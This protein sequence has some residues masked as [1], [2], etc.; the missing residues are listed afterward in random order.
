MVKSSKVKLIV[1]LFFLF[2]IY[3]FLN[4]VLNFSIPCLFHELTGLYCPGCGITRLFF[5]LLKFDFYQAFRYNPLIFL[6]I[7]LCL[8]YWIIKILLKKLKWIDITIPNYI[9]Y[10]LLV[11]VILFGILRNIPMFDYLAPYIL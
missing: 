5:S 10:C 3:F 6:L 11:V 1:I 9:Y 2:I 4:E 8:I 7:I